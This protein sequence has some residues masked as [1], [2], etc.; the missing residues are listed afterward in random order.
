M[1]AF[2]VIPV[3]RKMTPEQAW[4]EI[5]VFGRLHRRPWFPRWAVIGTHDDGS[6]EVMDL[7]A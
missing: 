7:D 3:P 5:L 2:D 1:I 4:E 6:Y